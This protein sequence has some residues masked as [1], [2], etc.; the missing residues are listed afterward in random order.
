MRKVEV[1]SEFQ[2]PYQLFAFFYLFIDAIRWS[3]RDARY[4]ICKGTQDFKNFVILLERVKLFWLHENWICKGNFVRV[5]VFKSC[6]NSERK[7]RITQN[8]ILNSNIW[9]EIKF[10]LH[11]TYFSPC[12]LHMLEH[13]MSLKSLN[14][15]DFQRLF[16]FCMCWIVCENRLRAFESNFDEILLETVK[17]SN[18]KIDIMLWL[19]KNKSR[20]ER[21]YRYS[22]FRV[23]RFLLSNVLELDIS[24]LSAIC[25]GMYKNKF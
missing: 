15:A 3:A 11:F 17:Q 18:R 14:K 8:F 12:R 24:K 16:E 1:S 7:T 25:G 21:A 5:E 13:A 4:R 6:R 10:G 19:D 9:R 2:M 23:E 20:I 22:M